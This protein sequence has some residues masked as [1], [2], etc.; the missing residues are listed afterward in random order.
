MN[1]DSHPSS[2]PSALHRR[3]WLRALAAATS[4]VLLSEWLP[5]L[6]G[7][8]PRQPTKFQLA[9][10]TLP[11][12]D[13]PLIRALEGIKAAGYDYV[14]WGTTHRENAGDERVPVLAAD[15]TLDQGANWAKSVATWDWHP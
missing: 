6:D 11:Y 4:G 3:D 7:A 13:F 2:K 15:A 12:S 1:Q 9:C 10:M 14:A 5:S 8:E